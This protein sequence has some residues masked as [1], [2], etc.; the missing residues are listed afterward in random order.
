MVVAFAPGGPADIVARLVAQLLQDKL[1]QQVVVDNRAGAGGNIAAR[2]VAK[3]AADGYTLFVTA[4]SVAVNRTLYK[5]P[6]FD[7]L[8]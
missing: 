7:A 5:D 2:L 6:G 8:C 4:S 1:G 3:E